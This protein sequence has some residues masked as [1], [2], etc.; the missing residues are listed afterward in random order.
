MQDS[1]NLAELTHRIVLE[2]LA[3]SESQLNSAKRS[4]K[5][6]HPEPSPLPPILEINSRCGQNDGGKLDK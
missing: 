1:I 2:V 4:D 6:F 5:G 3:K